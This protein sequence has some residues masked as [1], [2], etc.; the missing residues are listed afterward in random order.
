MPQTREHILLAKQV[1]VPML[2]VFM[3]KCDLVTDPELLELVELELRE[4][5]TH[6]GYPGHEVP[7]VRGS[8]HRRGR[9]S[10]RPRVESLHS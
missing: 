10:N 4:L 8:A 1:G 5:L 3:N 9:K 7:F 2:V 6:Y